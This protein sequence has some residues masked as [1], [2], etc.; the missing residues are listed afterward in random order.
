LN[1]VN[2]SNRYGVEQVMFVP[3]P[4]VL[5]ATAPTGYQPAETLAVSLAP[6][7]NVPAPFWRRSQPVPSVVGAPSR[8]RRRKRSSRAKSASEQGANVAV[9]EDE[10]T[11]VALAAPAP[12][13][14]DGLTRRRSFADLFLGKSSS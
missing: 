14:E 12:M 8:D 6:P 5:D 7:S 13:P 1:G 4:A 9:L 3:L 11:T 2:R 10:V